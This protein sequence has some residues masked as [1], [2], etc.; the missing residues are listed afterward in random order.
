MLLCTFVSRSI[1]HASLPVVNVQTTE[2]SNIV[3]RMSTI[4]VAEYQDMQEVSSIGT[5]KIAELMCEEGDSVLPGAPLFRVDLDQYHLQK[6][7]LE[8]QMNS[9]DRQL[10]FLKKDTVLQAPFSGTLCNVK[11]LEK[12]IRVTKGEEL[13]RLQDRSIVLVT[14]PFDIQD[15]ELLTISTTLDV[16]VSDAAETFI[17]EL[18]AISDEVAVID[19]IECFLVTIMIDN[20]GTLTAGMTATAAFHASENSISSVTS[21]TLEYI[22][23]EVLCAPYTGAVSAHA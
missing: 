18:Y 3:H 5:W 1:Y 17:G 10:A 21:G 23:D 12:G 7:Q 22:Q 16:S 19:N 6:Y 4:G 2:R 13:A 9:I 11:V 15:R 20:P 14:L 8:R